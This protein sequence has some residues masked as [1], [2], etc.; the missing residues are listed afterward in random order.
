MISEISPKDEMFTGDHEHYFS[1]GRSAV[2]CIRLGLQAARK[3]GVRKILDLPCGHG[4]VL[5]A[6]RDEFPDAEITAC[7][8]NRDG[9][10]FCHRAFGAVPAYSS[11][12]VSEIPLTRY[13]LIW[14]GSLLTHM[15]AQ[16]WYEF[17]ELFRDH[18]EPGGTLI[19][20]TH[21]RWPAERMRSGECLYG[22]SRA[23]KMLKGYRK[24]GFGF[25]QYDWAKEKR[26]SYGISLTEPWRAVKILEDIPELHL[27]C[28]QERGWDN[29]QDVIAA[30]KE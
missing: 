7:D 9:V 22:I 20:T 27:I 19:Y 3:S 30:T 8:L 14:C 16:S 28:Y 29:H 11:H 24:E 21:G 5:R 12:E 17:L 25:V 4:R 23:D 26:L 15:P 6:L 10:E 13:D 2:Q 1:V 18:L